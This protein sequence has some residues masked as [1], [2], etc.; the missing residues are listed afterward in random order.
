MV[1]GNR[2]FYTIIVLKHAISVKFSEGLWV[3]LFIVCAADLKY[4]YNGNTEKAAYH[5][6]KYK[7]PH[8]YALSFKMC[9]TVRHKKRQN[10]HS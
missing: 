5:Q 6:A 3:K 4:T 2:T 1:N 7:I 9:L 10:P 8:R